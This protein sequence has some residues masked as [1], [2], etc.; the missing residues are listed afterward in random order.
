MEDKGNSPQP[1]GE[2]GYQGLRSNSLSGWAA[3]PP[4][5]SVFL[6]P[7]IYLCVSFSPASLASPFT[8]P[9]FGPLF[10]HLGSPCL[11]RLPLHPSVSWLFIAQPL[12]Q[13]PS[14]GLPAWDWAPKLRAGSGRGQGSPRLKPPRSQQTCFPQAPLGA[15]NPEG[16]LQGPRGQEHEPWGELTLPV[17]GWG[18]G[19]SF[20]VL[21]LA[22][23]GSVAEMGGRG[24]PPCHRCWRRAVVTNRP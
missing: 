21:F 12:V 23:V 22:G 2:R 14:A 18:I 16:H 19:G 7:F 6:L 3:G 10:P 9:I 11:A 17:G 8:R 1:L 15:T 4:P 13:H 5:F 24:G 20:L